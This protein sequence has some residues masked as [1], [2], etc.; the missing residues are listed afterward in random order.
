MQAVAGSALTGVSEVTVESASSPL[1]SLAIAA[2]LQESLVALSIKDRD[3]GEHKANGQDVDEASA[4]R[5]IDLGR[6]K[7]RREKAE[8]TA[9][10]KDIVKRVISDKSRTQTFEETFTKILDNDKA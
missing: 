9:I 7:L 4:F 3:E 6:E 10:M 5:I 8:V 2:S 1:S